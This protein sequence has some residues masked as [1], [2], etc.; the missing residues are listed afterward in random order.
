[1]ADQPLF[2]KIIADR[3]RTDSVPPPPEVWAG[4][5]AAL[6]RRRRRRLVFWW[7]SGTVATAL[8]LGI[9]WWTFATPQP[10]KRGTEWVSETAPQPQ[11]PMAAASDRNTNPLVPTAPGAAQE[12]TN[13]KYT[14]QYVT[15]LPTPVPVQSTAPAAPMS[16]PSNPLTNTF[17]I[18]SGAGTTPPAPAELGSV[19][20]MEASAPVSV[21]LNKTWALDPLPTRS[22]FYLLAQ[23]SP[24]WLT[25]PSLSRITTPL[26]RPK[27]ATEDTKCYD[28]KRNSR[29]LLADVYAGPLT[30]TQRLSNP[31]SAEWNNYLNQRSATEQQGWGFTAGARIGAIFNRHFWVGSGLQ[32][33]Q[34]TEVFDFK[35]LSS[36]RYIIDLNPVTGILD[37]VDIIFGEASTTTYNRF[38]QLNIPLEMGYEWRQSR[39]GIR[40]QGGASWNI[41]FW[42]RGAILDPNTGMPAYFTPSEG[43]QSVFLARTGWSLQGSAHVFYHLQP[44]TRLF[45]EPYSSYTLGRITRANHPLQQRTLHYGLRLGVAKIF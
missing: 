29:A 11:L 43:E 15:P 37:T 41:W 26:K 30:A 38:G 2:E 17:L 35:D 4:V 22:Q 23:K 28:F 36:I 32:Y 14:T 21:Q 45:V 20:F 40:L 34:H 24:V 25:H 16:T 12:L 6:R 33:Q 3:L 39:G 8:L 10:P 18:E 31:V 13:S 9:G 42:K 19:P 5:D 1:M 7:T 44:R 27:K